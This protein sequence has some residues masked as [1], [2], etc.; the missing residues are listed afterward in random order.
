MK[1]GDATG[2]VVLAAGAVAIYFAYKALNKVGQTACD[3]AQGILHP[4]CVVANSF[5]AADCWLKTELGVNC[6]Q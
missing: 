2:L 6:G 5:S 1:A 4:N 3:V